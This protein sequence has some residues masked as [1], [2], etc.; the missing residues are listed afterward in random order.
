MRISIVMAYYNRE[1]QLKKT[2]ESIG[3][4]RINDYEIIIVDDASTVPLKCPYAK[5]IRIEPRNKWYHNPCIPFNRGFK[6]ATG[7]VVI[8]QNPECYHIG[9][10]LAYV[11]ENIKPNLY[12]TF[13][14]YAINPNE[15]VDFMDGISP[16][17]NNWMFRNP[18]RNGWFNHS[19][20]RPAAYHFC[21]AIMKKDL[22]LI[23][24][25]DE[26][27]AGGVS[28]DD[29]DLIRRIR[30]Q[31]EVT[32]VDDPYVLHQYHSPFC[33]MSKNMRVLHTRNKQL[34]NSEK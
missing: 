9:D 10:I 30:K 24:G 28:Y 15:T 33:Y 21:S 8:I 19:I 7:D 32:I 14:C 11:E 26:R 22:D 13:G 18:E 34:F 20:Y 5:V 4:S 3:R 23:G 6:C 16:E 1:Q 2:L 27:Y 17:L 25:F 31:M 12:I 29:D